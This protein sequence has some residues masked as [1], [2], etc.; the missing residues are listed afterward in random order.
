M[1]ATETK[2]DAIFD[3]VQDCRE[4]LQSGDVAH[5]VGTDGHVVAFI[6]DS[7]DTQILVKGLRTKNET[8]AFI[9]GWTAGFSG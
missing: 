6:N 4:K 5:Y 1:T 3:A 2:V 9:R 7:G 8:A